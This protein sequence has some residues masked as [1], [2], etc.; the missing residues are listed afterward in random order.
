MTF[1]ILMSGLGC[2]P[3][4]FKCTGSNVMRQILSLRDDRF[5]CKSF[6]I[7]NWDEKNSLADVNPIYNKT[8]HNLIKFFQSFV[9][10]A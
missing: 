5:D 6:E 3:S 10:V 4:F 9:E 8:N 2:V 7:W 1:P